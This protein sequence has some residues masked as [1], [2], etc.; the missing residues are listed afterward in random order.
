MIFSFVL[1]AGCNS[2]IKESAVLI[3]TSFAM[4]R[5]D[6]LD[7]TYHVKVILDKYSFPSQ[8]CTIGI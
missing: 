5:Q 7:N 6:I 4:G 8:V 2:T 1:F 3:E